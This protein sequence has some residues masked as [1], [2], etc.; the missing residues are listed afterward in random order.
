MG[1]ATYVSIKKQ[2]ENNFLNMYEMDVVD[3]KGKH[4]PYYFATR[5]SDGELVCQTDEQTEVKPDGVVIYAVNKDAGGRGRLVL[6]RQYRYPLNRYI[7]ELPA[8][9]IDGRETPGEAAVRELREET[10]FSFSE[11]CGGSPGLRRVFYQAQGLCDECNALVFGY[12]Q[13]TASDK[14]RESS[15]DITVVLADRREA[16]RILEN[17]EV[18]IRCAYML[19]NFIHAVDGDEFGFLDVPEGLKGR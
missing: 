1:R 12:A 17:E 19:M 11:Y 3:T 14:D 10:G 18:S 16:L 9:L 8:G 13:G 5:K 7:Y 15:E 2:T 4:F 6:V